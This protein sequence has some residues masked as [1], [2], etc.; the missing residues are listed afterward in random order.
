MIIP[1]AK[2]CGDKSNL[3]SVFAYALE[4]TCATMHCYFLLVQAI[5]TFPDTSS[6]IQII[7]SLFHEIKVW[8]EFISLSQFFVQFS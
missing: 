8:Y 1:N 7:I 6:T 2:T 5:E 4:T 3:H